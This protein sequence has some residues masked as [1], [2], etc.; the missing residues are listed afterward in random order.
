MAAFSQTKLAIT[1]ADGFSLGATLFQSQP[2]NATPSLAKRIVVI[3]NAATGALQKFY[4]P[5]AA[6]LVQNG[7]DAVLSYDYRGIGESLPKEGTLVGFKANIS[8]WAFWDQ[9]AIIKYMHSRFGSTSDII[10]IGHSVGGHIATINPLS[11]HI[12]RSLFVTCG[13]AYYAAQGLS[14][15]PS[16]ALAHFVLFPGFAW[17]YNYLPCRELGLL[18]IEDIPKG[19]ARQWSYWSRSRSYLARQPKYAKAT[20]EWKNPLLLLSFSDDALISK[21]AISDFASL[22]KSADVDWRH[23]DPRIDLGIESVGHMGFFFSTNQQILWKP[24]LSYI[25]YGAY[26]VFSHS[27]QLHTIL[28]AKL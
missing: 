18:K 2:T 22:L 27:T 5:F 12:V 28:P 20:S 23:L 7:V 9:P 16:L 17:W 1:T 3:I 11:K 25:L 13:S 6:F 15:I 24:V 26:P 10:L 21:Q 14:N 19:V 8:D 4:F